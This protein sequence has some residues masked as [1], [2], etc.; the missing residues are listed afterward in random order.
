MRRDCTWSEL[1]STQ[2]IVGGGTP[3]A[4]QESEPPVLLENPW[5]EGGS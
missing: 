1:P 4:E 2:E 3:W 5:K